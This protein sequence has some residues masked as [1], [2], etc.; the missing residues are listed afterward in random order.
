VSEATGPDIEWAEPLPEDCP[1][2]DAVQPNH[3][4]Y[5]RLVDSIPPTDSDF[6]SQR[7]KQP[8]MRFN[9]TECIARGCSV[10]S[11]RS[12]CDRV[13]KMKGHRGQMVA[14]F[15]LP[16]S[17]GVVKQTLG[18]PKHHSW[19]RAKGFDPAPLCSDVTSLVISESDTDAST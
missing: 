14:R 4:T 9:T 15:S 17:S 1:P 11:V 2:L 18:D 12:A 6:W 10:F 5:Y 16:P 19:W 3:E 7:K 13:L 8:K